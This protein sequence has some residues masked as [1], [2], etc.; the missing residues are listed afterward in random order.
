[1]PVQQHTYVMRTPALSTGDRKK[2]RYHISEVRFEQWSLQATSIPTQN[3]WTKGGAIYWTN[4]CKLFT[5]NITLFGTDFV[6]YFIIYEHFSFV[7]SVRKGLKR[8]RHGI[9]LN[10]QK[11]NRVHFFRAKQCS[12]EGSA[13]PRSPPFF[14]RSLSFLEGFEGPVLSSW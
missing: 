13:D 4:H 5:C 7:I 3:R 10:I 2:M 12:A 9:R 1:M 14:S 11:E 6:T 8:V